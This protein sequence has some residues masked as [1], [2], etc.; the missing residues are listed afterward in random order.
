MPA[1]RGLA[2]PRAPV[3]SGE[4]AGLVSTEASLPDSSHTRSDEACGL[5]QPHLPVGAGARPEGPASQDAG[6]EVR[7]VVL[8]V[9]GH[10]EL[11]DGVRRGA[12][13]PRTTVVRT[14][15]AGVNVAETPLVAIAMQGADSTNHKSAPILRL[16]V[17]VV[18]AHE[19]EHPVRHPRAR[20]LSESLKEAGH[21][22]AIL[23]SQLYLRPVAQ[24]VHLLG[25]LAREV[26]AR[27]PEEVPLRRPR[28]GRRVAEEAD[29]PERVVEEEVL[30][31]GQVRGLRDR[32]ARLLR[33]EG[34]HT[35]CCRGVLR[36]PL[37]EAEAELVLRERGLRR[38]HPEVMIPRHSKQEDLLCAL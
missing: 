27:L 31:A 13:H 18:V 8:G 16:L 4:F 28:V 3:R 5:V 10:R 20:T 7:E 2:P 9:G 17:A 32:E 37:G 1:C 15:G 12:L 30:R 36:K 21:V 22:H 23:A 6:V 24:Q 25:R 14:A 38:E 34:L 29:V 26:R 19:V 11:G 35:S 33:Q